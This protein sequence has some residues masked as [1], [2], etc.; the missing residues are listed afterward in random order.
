MVLNYIVSNYCE[1]IV[2]VSC[3]MNYM[4]NFNTNF[5]TTSVT[6]KHIPENCLVLSRKNI[7]IHRRRSFSISIEEQGSD[8]HLYDHCISIASTLWVNAIEQAWV[9]L[10]EYLVHQVMPF[11]RFM[12]Q[13]TWHCDSSDYKMV[14]KKWGI[15]NAFLKKHLQQSSYQNH[16]KGPMPLCLCDTWGELMDVSYP[17]WVRWNNSV[18]GGG[19]CRSLSFLEIHESKR[20]T[21]NGVW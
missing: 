7:R 15:L 9:L 14:S 16:L 18:S 4:L 17:N 11:W 6:L 1:L 13:M 5:N 8:H 20:Q 21:L 19:P 2:P 12:L 10:C 3:W